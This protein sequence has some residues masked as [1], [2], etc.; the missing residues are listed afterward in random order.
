MSLWSVNFDLERRT[1]LATGLTLFAY[2]ACHFV[3]HATG[4]LFLDNLQGIG[5]GV[6]LAPWR[7]SFGVALLLF[8][9][10]FHMSLGLFALYRRRHLRMPAIEAWQLG[11]GLTIPLLLAP[12]VTDT[13]VAVLAFGLEDS[14]FRIL[15]HFWISD[16]TFG[17]PRQFLLMVLIWSHGCI[18]IH[19]WL[20]Y[21][22]WYRRRIILF[23]L[24]ALALP[25]LAIAGLLNSG[26]E[27]IL[28]AYMDEA[29]IEAHG[30]P[31]KGTPHAHVPAML[32][33]IILCLQISYLALLA[34]VLLLR[35]LRNTRE[36]M[37]DTVRIDYRD[38]RSIRAPFGFSVL[39]ASRFKGIPHASVCGGR[40]RCST[41][42]FRVLYGASELPPPGPAERAALA[43]IG[44]PEGVRL[45]CQTRPRCDIG[46]YPMLPADSPLDGLCVLLDQGREL[47]VTA[48]F[49]DLRDSTKLAANRLPY[50]AIYIVD[51]YI[52]AT[53]NAILAEGGHVTS[54]AGDG[55]MS[56]FRL[57]G[58]A[59]EGARAALRAA[60]GVWRAIRRVSRDFAQD[61]EAPLAF[62]VGLHSGLAI[63]GA[64][65][66]TDRQS[67]QFLGDT[68]NIAAR[69]ESL[70]KEMDCVALVSSQTC[71]AAGL[72]PP[73]AVVEAPIRGRDAALPAFPF[74]KLGDFE[75]W[76]ASGER[77][78]V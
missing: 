5:H 50:D 67:L 14:Y 6:I 53:T 28:R 34:A 18:G 37:F 26:W 45:A 3:S 33:S 61:L 71:D 29:V 47:F 57:D 35:A 73:H 8:C 30:P 52:R 32:A 72:R 62:G 54:V 75:R 78:A 41:C 55:V 4:L 19:M 21:R 23:L 1:R 60:S 25:V 27:L 11:L 64:V 38:G 22:D 66:P 24:L 20:R 76:V 39:E 69:L 16:P 7:S 49:V 10:T 43:Q 63:V 59:D 58:D 51:S 44:A 36:R 15:Y 2:A 65:G 17:L 42:R 12:H 74:K 68:G 9:F 77:T 56:L 31:A 48:M 46:V 70:T 40:A 13:R